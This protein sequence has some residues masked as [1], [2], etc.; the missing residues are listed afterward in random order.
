MDIRLPLIPLYF[1]EKSLGLCF[2][3]S[4]QNPIRHHVLISHFEKYSEQHSNQ[5]PEPPPNVS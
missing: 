2:T 4:V 5:L 1:D 3:H